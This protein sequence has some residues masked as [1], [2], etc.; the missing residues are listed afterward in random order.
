MSMAAVSPLPPPPQPAPRSAEF[1]AD[2]VHLRDAVARWQDSTTAPIGWLEI[3]LIP[4][5]LGFRYGQVRTIPQATLVGVLSAAVHLLAPVVATTV[6]A[7]WADA[8][9]WTWLGVA[10]IMAAFDIFG[11]RV[12][13]ESSPTGE[14]LF[15]LPAAIDREEDLHELVDFTRRWWRL[16][17]VA[18]AAAALTLA[19]LAASAGV[20]PEAFRAFHPGSLLLLA[21][22][23]H[24]FIEGQLMVFIAFRLFVRES[25]F[26]HRLS[27][28]DPVA[29][30]PVQAMLHTWFMSIGAGSPMLVAYG[31]SVG[32]L[33]APVSLDLLLAP[34]AGIAL[35][36]LGLTLT[37][38][39]NLRRSVQRIVRHTRDATLE[40]LRE[41]IESL[42]PRKRELTPTESEQLQ[43]LLSTYAAV[44]AAPTGP[45]GA[46]TLGHAVTTLAIPT[47]T[48]FLV[49]MSEV[50]AE[51]L[52]DQLLP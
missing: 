10:A 22:L 38:V 16:R 21:L 31:L 20:A 33:I 5:V 6:T 44:R 52:L 15:A 45:S 25:R 23:V 17:T 35:I 3:R 50:Y 32:I 7:T 28:L 1:E 34:L 8:P 42:E 13:G 27:W 30:P 29:S 37:S 19:I 39:I 18:P 46:Q 11:T 26:V 4:R 14:S 41:R 36:G 24:E 48:F 2:L 12:H 40:S 9:V 51:R 47:L 49:V 43:A